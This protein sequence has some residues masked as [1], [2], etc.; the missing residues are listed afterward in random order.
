VDPRVVMAIA[1]V[2]ITSGIDHTQLFLATT[3]S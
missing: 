1:D 3:Q 2:G